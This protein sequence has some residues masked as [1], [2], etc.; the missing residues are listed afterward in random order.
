MNTIRQ[1]IDDGATVP[2]HYTLAPN[3]LRV[4]MQVL[5][6]EFLALAESEV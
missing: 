6:A 1:S 2:L 4:E 3:E 5:E